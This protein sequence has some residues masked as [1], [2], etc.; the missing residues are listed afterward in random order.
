LVGAVV[1]TATVAAAVASVVV[2]VVLPK[3]HNS[4]NPNNNNANSSN[5]GSTTPVNNQ[6]S[7]QGNNSQGAPT[8]QSEATTINTLL[9]NSSQ[10]RS[11]WN[12]N[13]LVTNV[14]NCVSISSDITQ[15]GD[16][17]QQRQTE[18]AQA[19]NLQ[20]GAIPNGATL[21]S[22]LM[23]ALQISLNI[24]NDYLAWARQQQS[25][26]CTVGTGSTYYQE[27]SNADSQATADKET[28]LSTW[29]PIASTYGLEQFDASQI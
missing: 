14:G 1:A 11:Q 21:K 6:S 22:Q 19:G 5:S 20:V 15:I 23:T 13:V 2:F 7:T 10:S 8:A 9:L 17:A 24:D 28:F 29:D 12:A 4:A 25:S 18:L 27:A 3:T 16:I 26:G